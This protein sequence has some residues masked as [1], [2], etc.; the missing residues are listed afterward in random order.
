MVK[1]FSFAYSI[2]RSSSVSSSYRGI[3]LNVKNFLNTVSIVSFEMSR[4]S[5]NS[6]TLQ[7]LPRLLSDA[8]TT[9]ITL[10]LLNTICALV[11]L[12]FDSLSLISALN[13]GDEGLSS[14]IIFSRTFIVIFINYISSVFTLRRHINPPTIFG[15]IILIHIDS[16]DCA[17][18]FRCGLI[19]TVFICPFF[20]DGI[21][22]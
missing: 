6:N 13:S 5:S 9:L 15:T 20:K 8:V 3:L 19:V 17:L 4:Y 22:F 16:I 12:I 10:V 14:R 18:S 21:I 1:F 2:F 7:R 11:P